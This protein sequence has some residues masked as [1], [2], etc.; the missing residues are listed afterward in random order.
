MCK[1]EDGV[2]RSRVKEMKREASEGGSV[3]W[4][5]YRVKA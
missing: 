4:E 1:H 3:L 5:K 2:D